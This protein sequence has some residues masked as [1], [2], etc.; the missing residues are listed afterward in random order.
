MT[1]NADTESRE[2]SVVFG[3]ESPFSRPTFIIHLN[4]DYPN[5]LPIS[6][7]RQNPSNEISPQ[8]RNSESGREPPVFGDTLINSAALLSLGARFL[9]SQDPAHVLFERRQKRLSSQWSAGTLVG[10]QDF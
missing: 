9:P 1:K 5:T 2:F 7:W 3:E 6:T 4:E 10:T 8:I